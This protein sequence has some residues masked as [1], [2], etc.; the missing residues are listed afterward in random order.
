MWL[1]LDLKDV[2]P[3]KGRNVLEISLDGRPAELEGWVA[4]EEVEVVVEYGPYPSSL[5]R[6]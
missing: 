5:R 2:R 1:E 6:G 4:L 3:V